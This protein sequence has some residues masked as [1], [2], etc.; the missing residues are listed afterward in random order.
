MEDSRGL[1]RIG[2][3]VGDKWL[4]WGT[5]LKVEPTEFVGGLGM[6]YERKSVVEDSTAISLSNWKGD[7]VN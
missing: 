5:I 3:S 7:V 1:T 6:R 4:N 2:E